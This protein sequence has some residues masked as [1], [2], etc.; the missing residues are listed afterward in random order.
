MQIKYL[1]SILMLCCLFLSQCTATTEKQKQQNASA[2]AADSHILLINSFDKTFETEAHPIFVARLKSD[3]KACHITLET[4]DMDGPRFPS[5]EAVTEY[6]TQ[7]HTE[8]VLFLA[9]SFLQ[10]GNTLNMLPDALM[11]KLVDAVNQKRLWTKNFNLAEVNSQSDDRKIVAV[12]A[13]D[14]VMKVMVEEK[15]I[16]PC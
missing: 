8:R 7:H 3:L 13:A 16:G 14:A 12:K 1:T 9:F 6:I 11:L 4:P 15:A 10:P 2:A 5:G